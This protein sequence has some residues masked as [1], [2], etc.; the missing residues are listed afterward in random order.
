M[1]KR[2][3]PKILEYAGYPLV[4]PLTGGNALL[5]IWDF[6]DGGNFPDKTE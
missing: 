1:G 6:R 3:V 2:N 5:T 4:F